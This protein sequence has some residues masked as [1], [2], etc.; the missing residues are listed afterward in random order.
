MFVDA[1]ALVAIVLGEP[2]AQPLAER[3][4]AADDPVT[5]PIAI[6][7][8]VLAIARIRKGG[9][10]AARSDLQ[11]LIDL[12]GIGLVPTTPE[13]AE[14]ALSAFERFGKGQRHPARLN[15]GDCFAY[16]GAKRRR[17]PLLFKGADFSKTDVNSDFG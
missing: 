4:D 5:S 8:A 12:A 1:S 9:L 17:V 10:A 15:M 13:D 16:A 3:L 11:V 14:I 6:Y 7:E 2:D